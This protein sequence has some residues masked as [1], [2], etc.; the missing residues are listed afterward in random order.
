MDDA[1]ALLNTAKILLL[2]VKAGGY[3]KK[4]KTGTIIIPPPSPIIEPSKPATNP[5]GINHSSSSIVRFNRKYD[6][7]ILIAILG[8]CLHRISLLML[9]RWHYVIHK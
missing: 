5:S 2:A 7:Y 6:F 9:L 4:V 1:A 3:P 8:Y